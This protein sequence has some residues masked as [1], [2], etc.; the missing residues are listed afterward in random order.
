M[1]FS[2][3]RYAVES[4][5]TGGRWRVWWG[6]VVGVWDS[7]LYQSNFEGFRLEGLCLSY[8]RITMQMTHHACIGP[9]TDTLEIRCHSGVSPVPYFG[10]LKP[11]S[12]W[13][14]MW[15]SQGLGLLC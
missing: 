6:D 13:N 5:M 14:K 10:G 1:I 4:A 2:L 15:Q 12:L 11:A 7:G 9:W 3:L 8:L